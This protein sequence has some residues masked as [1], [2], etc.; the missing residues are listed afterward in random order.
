MIWRTIPIN[1]S[2]SLLMK[3]IRTKSSSSP[4]DNNGKG[5]SFSP[6][7]LCAVALGSCISTIVGMQMERL[8]IEL[9]GMRVEVSKEMFK[10]KPRRIAKLTTEIW[11][12]CAVSEDHKKVIE[13][14]AKTCPVHLS[15]HSE[16]EKPIHFHWC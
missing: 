4:L 11:M 16:I 5:E 1:W 6:T 3:N 2:I 13:R 8:G 14:A 12:P 9:A 15:L 7:D 10:Y